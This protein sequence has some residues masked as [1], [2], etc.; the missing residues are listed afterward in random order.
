MT[1]LLLFLILVAQIALIFCVNE[2]R[3]QVEGVNDFS[4]EDVQVKAMT[5]QAVEAKEKVVEAKSR[6]PR[7]EN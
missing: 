4:K 2:L 7:K 6:L 5:E 1:D 3:K